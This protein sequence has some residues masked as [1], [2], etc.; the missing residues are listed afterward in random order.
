MMSRSR[1]LPHSAV[2]NNV[3]WFEMNEAANSGGL[4]LGNWNAGVPET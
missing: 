4:L 3:A 1:E 2:G